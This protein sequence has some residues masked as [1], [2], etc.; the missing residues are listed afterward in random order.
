MV[1]YLAIQGGFNN[2]YNL[3]Q[4]PQ[5]GLE[6]EPLNP[7]CLMMV[8][9]FRCYSTKPKLYDRL[10]HIGLQSKGLNGCS[11]P[12]TDRGAMIFPIN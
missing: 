5:G 1:F 6:D 10:C 12:N 9:I 3:N 2:I 4:T 7:I 11:V 8:E